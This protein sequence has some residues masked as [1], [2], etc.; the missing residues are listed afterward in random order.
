MANTKGEYF[1]VTSPEGQK[2]TLFGETKYDA[3]A[4][5]VR[6]DR[7]AYSNSQYTAIKTNL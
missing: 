3:I 5:A 4:K 6:L 7:F 2:R 1:L